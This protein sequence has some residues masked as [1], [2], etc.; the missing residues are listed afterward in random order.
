M[1][2]SRARSKS[3]KSDQPDANQFRLEP[4]HAN[5]TKTEKPFPSLRSR[6]RKISDSFDTDSNSYS[7]K[8]NTRKSRRIEAK[9]ANL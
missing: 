1:P 5:N 2:L 6:K 8:S 7:T 4:I 3:V 9:D